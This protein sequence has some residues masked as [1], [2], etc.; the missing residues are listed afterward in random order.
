MSGIG[1]GMAVQPQ[2]EISNFAPVS[3]EAFKTQTASFRNSF[4]NLQTSVLGVP[5]WRQ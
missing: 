3:H 2:A 5:V 4:L 1:V